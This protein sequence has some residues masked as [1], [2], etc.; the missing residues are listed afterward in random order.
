VI[1]PEALTA[2]GA[3]VVGPL[4]AW[5]SYKQATRVASLDTKAKVLRID[6]EAYDRARALYESG[7][8][9]LEDQLG[10]LRTQLNEE[11]DVS[12]RLRSQVNNLEDTVARMRRQLISA[13]IEE[14][15]RA[16][17]QQQQPP[18]RRRRDDDDR[19]THER[20]T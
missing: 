8:A 2:I 19:T 6:V 12:Q 7:I 9:Q 15:A 13:G 5:L 17:R 16:E 18:P 3:I 4:A 11:R 20:E 14:A 10:R 1:S